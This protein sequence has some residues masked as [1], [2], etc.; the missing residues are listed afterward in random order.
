MVFTYNLDVAKLALVYEG[1]SDRDDNLRQRIEALRKTLKTICGESATVEQC[2][3]VGAD[4]KTERPVLNVEVNDKTA[5]ID[6][7]SLSIQC[8]DQLL[9][10][11]LSSITQKMSHALL[12]L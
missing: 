6:V 11:L 2:V 4:G 12:P 9:Q 8:N 3:E 5:R 7:E 1:N 10:H